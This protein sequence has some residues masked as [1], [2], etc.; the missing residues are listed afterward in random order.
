M[1]KQNGSYEKYMVPSK[2]D[3][4]AQCVCYSAGRTVTD[5][6]IH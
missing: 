4:E 6:H 1:N 2:M 3:N 5:N